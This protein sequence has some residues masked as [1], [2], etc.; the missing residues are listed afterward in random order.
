MR[1]IKIEW[2]CN[3]CV[4]LKDFKVWLCINWCVVPMVGVALLDGDEGDSDV[5]WWCR[6]VGGGGRCDAVYGET[7][8]R[9]AMVVVMVVTL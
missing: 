7:R 1:Y 8:I 4:D 6:L 3:A 5:G 2:M 9:V